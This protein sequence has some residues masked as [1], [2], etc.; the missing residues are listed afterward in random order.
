MRIAFTLVLL[1]VAA[2]AVP[3][4]D[5]PVPPMPLAAPV[6]PPTD[7]A[8]DA[9]IADAIGRNPKA[10]DAAV[11]KLIDLG[12]A[13]VPALAQGLWADSDTRRMCIALL[14]AIGP[15]ARSA[16]PS[17]VRLLTSDD[18][19]V[20]GSAARSL[21][22]L[23]T[24][25]AIPALKKL[26]DDKFPAVRLTAA[27][28]LI[29]LGASAETVLPML[30]KA[31][32]SDRQEEGYTAARLLGLLGPEAAGA[33]PAINNALTGADPLLVAR[34]ADAL[35]RVGPGAKDAVPALK[36]RVVED[37][38]PGP[39]RVQ[40]A[41]AAWR[42]ARDPD[43]AKYLRDSL[44]KT[45]GRG[46]AHAPLWRID[47]S[48]DTLDELAKQLKSQEPSDVI[49]AAEVLGPKAKD[50]GPALVK[51]IRPDLDP[52]KL[53]AVITVLGD[54][55][56]GAPAWRKDALELLVK[57][58]ESKTPGLS[59]AAAVAVYRIA[60][61]PQAARVIT[62]YLEDKEL[63]LEAAEAL[64]ELRPAD[65]AVVIELLAALDSPD[66]NVK[67][68]SAVALWRIEKH[69]QA[70]PSIIK[71]L[72]SADPKVRALAAT[73][74]GGEFGADAKAAVPEL[75][76]RLF[77][78]FASVRS[79]SAEAL[80]RIGSGAT[81]A[82]KPLLA[83]LDGDE[84]AFVQSAAC[85]A[86]GLVQPADKDDVAAV[87]K[88]KL[89]HPDALVRAHAALALFLVGGDKTGEQ[90]AATGLTWRSHPVRVTA[91]EAAWRMNKNGRAVT[92]LVRALE[93]SN[94][95]GTLYENERY[96]AART[97]GRIGAD[98]KD[99]VPE[100]LKLINHRDHALATAAR[101]AVKAIDPEAAK[102][103]GV[104]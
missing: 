102:K 82:T 41:L 56:P 48:K 36:K 43:A 81:D 72:R 32:K 98:A 18:L 87:L 88:K 30:A 83:L 6:G 80:G 14:G 75:V 15:D 39:Y 52:A 38:N 22:S 55:G 12:P 8:L 89:D 7:A 94:L 26:L 35:G 19:E 10:A 65:Q 3:A 42:V 40:V 103:A 60:P 100:L 92:L 27:E 24:P 28:A 61:T 63:R 66:D 97:L 68:A 17:L 90:E 45:Q 16:A 104:K 23:G 73:D 77:D 62:D 25:A 86:L 33:V 84:P 31:L 49:A 95:E 20:R 21:G 51:L 85:E 44:P 11:R 101:T 71:R 67:L 53:L 50:A 91:A 5:P 93:E 58:A 13:A 70:L 37:A 2:A 47:Q 34:L 69:A 96:M 79:A 54:V 99:A 59:V 74:I 64:K 29:N 46:L 57:I 9:L 4:A 78:P 1:S 76:K